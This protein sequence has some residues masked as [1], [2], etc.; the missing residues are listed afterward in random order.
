MA[1][2]SSS[3]SSMVVAVGFMCNVGNKA[4]KFDRRDCTSSRVEHRLHESSGG[5]YE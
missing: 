1:G 4:E 3:L 2:S 5:R